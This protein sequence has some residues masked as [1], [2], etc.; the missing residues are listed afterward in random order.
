MKKRS[1]NE[2]RQQFLEYF[3]ENQ[4]TIVPGSSLIPGN[5]PTLFFTN[6]GMF[7][8]LGKEGIDIQMITTSEI[9]ISVVVNEAHLEKG[10]QAVHKAFELDKPAP[11]CEST[12]FE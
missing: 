11:G 8:A 12:F 6:A 7:Q 10:V 4:H 2:I 5:D 3:K 1:S 9:K